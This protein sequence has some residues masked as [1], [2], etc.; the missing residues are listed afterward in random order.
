ML[1][2]EFHISI[3]FNPMSSEP[4]SLDDDEKGIVSSKNHK[5]RS[6]SGKKPT[7]PFVTRVVR[8]LRDGCD[9]FI[10]RMEDMEHG[11]RDKSGK[12]TQ[13]GIEHDYEL[14]R[15]RKK[16]DA[17]RRERQ[18]R[19]GGKDGEGGAPVEAL[20]SGGR[21]VP[22]HH[23]EHSRRGGYDSEEDDLRGMHSEDPSNP[24][25]MRNGHIHEARPGSRADPVVPLPAT[26][27]FGHKPPLAAIH[28]NTRPQNS[29]GPRIRSVS[30]LPGPDRGRRSHGSRVLQRDVSPMPSEH[31]A[32]S[33]LAKVNARRNIERTRPG[34][35]AGRGSQARRT[36][37]LESEDEERPGSDEGSSSEDEDA[38]EAAKAARAR[39]RAR[40]LTGGPAGER[41]GPRQPLVETAPPS[42]IG[43]GLRG[44]AAAE[45]EH[46]SDDIAEETED[47]REST[48]AVQYNEHEDFDDEYRTAAGTDEPV[49][50]EHEEI[51]QTSKQKKIFIHAQPQENFQ[52]ESHKMDQTRERRPYNFGAQ[53]IAPETFSTSPSQQ[54]TSGRTSRPYA[55]PNVGESTQVR[56]PGAP[57]NTRKCF[58][59]RILPVGKRI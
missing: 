22:P 56:L 27:H 8:R 55:N 12:K 37:P 36:N 18:E 20:M 4:K 42:V 34:P 31:S 57:G 6:S 28:P 2:P 23:G 43:S 44:G 25:P 21:G 9:E 46:F 16:R 24:P 33:L 14:E 47:E 50:E 49:N 53:A 10:E 26:R 30:P 54:K 5:H 35:Q 11:Y 45:V 7:T 17:R 19:E 3:A 59:S 38:D 52:E 48:G 29:R 39:R 13:K 40:G 32:S 1:A 58:L 15:R 51:G 41:A